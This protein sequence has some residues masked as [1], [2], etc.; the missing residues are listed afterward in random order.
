M[1]KARKV[2]QI[3]FS[4]FNNVGVL[5]E[6]TEALAEANVNIEAIC[7]I[8]WEDLDAS[9]MMVTDNNTKAKKVISKMGA[10]VAVDDVIALEVQN[11]VGQLYKAA[12]KIATA[13]IDIYYMYGT[14][15]KGKMTLIFR[16]END[17]KTLK[18][19]EE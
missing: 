6:I 16:T 13:G 9:F 1:A 15:S 14:P 10:E 3:R 2:K 4:M 8:G 5:M 12:K 18:V 11:E 7:A 17:R 19:L